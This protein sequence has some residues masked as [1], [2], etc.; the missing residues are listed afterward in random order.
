MLRRSIK[1]AWV[2]FFT[3][4]GRLTAIQL[5]TIPKIL[6]GDNIILASPTASGKTE[7]VIAPLAQLFINN[8]WDGLAILYVVPTRA[9][10]NDAYIRIKDPL[11][12]MGIST[13][14]KH[15]DKPYISEN[16]KCNVLITT[17]ESLDS[18]ICRRHDIFQYLQAIIIDEI[19]LLDN[20]FRGDHLR[21]LLKR[22]KNIPNN[23]PY[24]HLLS[25]TLSDPRGIASRYV[26]NYK[27]VEVGEPREIDW[28]FASDYD[29]VFQIIIEKKWKKILCFCNY[30][31][32][33]EVLSSDLSQQWSM[34]SVFAHHGCLSRQERETA[35][36]MMQKSKYVVCVSTSTL[37][38]GIDIGDIDVVILAEVP[39]SISSLLQRIGRG[40]RRTNK[41]NIL[42]VVNSSEES[43]H[44]TQMFEIAKSGQLPTIAYSPNLSVVIQQIFSYL[45]QYPN[46]ATELEL[47]D[48]VNCLCNEE[49]TNLILRHLLEKEWLILKSGKW[50]ASTKV[51]NMGE[52]G[53]IHSNIPDTQ[54]YNVI[55]KSSGRKIGV[56]HGIV[57][58]VFIL[59]RKKWKII[60]SSKG[61]VYVEPAKGNAQIPIFKKNRN[62]GAFYSYLP[63]SLKSEEILP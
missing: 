45:F 7:A 8:Q 49:K 57:D 51:M 9:L 29:E 13:K 60:Y 23:N 46:G 36:H 61:N 40:N 42:A 21:V 59:S 27:V 19:H 32:S 33:V 39:W 48:L 41:I 16:N 37:E 15:G 35:E 28:G 25:A 4:F 10:A 38:I 53:Y 50:Y 47:I 31:E 2:P 5:E 30:R 1:N 17:P 44:L 22:L 6:D 24:I 58:K 54:K 26:D 52:H 62:Y 34:F 43:D 63:D 20:T 12:E 11:S 18:L 55:D 14:L 3:R 56:V